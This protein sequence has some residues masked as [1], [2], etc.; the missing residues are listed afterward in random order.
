L[1]QELGPYTFE[2]YHRKVNVS[3]SP[4]NTTVSF[5]EFFSFHPVP[6]LTN[7]S[8]DDPV[9]TLNVA[10]LGAIEVILAKSPSRFSGIIQYLA[11]LVE[12]WKDPRVQGLFTTRPVGELL[13][14]YKDPL[15]SRIS[16]VVPGINPMVALVK[17]M[18]FEEE[19]NPDPSQR[20]TV[21]TGID[22]I[23]NVC[24]FIQWHGMSHVDDWRPP[25]VEP[26]QGTD[27]TQFKPGL[28]KGDEL[29]VWV[30][31]VFRY[32]TLIEGFG[33]GAESPKVG[34]VPVLRFRP[35]PTQREPDP[36]YY[37]SVP[38]LMNITAPMAADMGGVGPPLFLSLPGFCYADDSLTEGVEGITCDHLKHDIYLD[39]EPA[40]GIT[41]SALKTLMLSS[42]FGQK[43]KAVDPHV[44]DTFLPI[45]WAHES[46]EAAP[47]QLAG[48]K[49]MLFGQAAG[50]FFDTKAQP[51]GIVVGI[52]GGVLFVAGFVMNRPQR[53][54]E[55]E[56]EGQ[57]GGDDGIGA[58]L[59]GPGSVPASEGENEVLFEG[60]AR[61][62]NS[63]GGGPG[64]LM[65][66]RMTDTE[67]VLAGTAEEP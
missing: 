47:E 35:D 23:D 5:N 21:A 25:H 64:L 24:E 59:L 28:R 18:T 60:S 9:T 53:V 46:S 66:S 2:K 49:M 50:Q 40:T 11:R 26:V 7:G 37:Q 54:W 45:F 33:P 56:D 19:S 31:D 44:K 1:Q 41:L 58:P 4:D 67:E 27:A 32:F 57:G 62:S 16:H 10:L 6:E 65:E 8:L 42:W 12:G 13:F 34:S 22:N 14:G 61:N 38:G 15:L 43:Y 17:N 20:D 3:F 29:Q 48:F 52:I 51:V 36:R 55:E 63:V 39:V 30:G